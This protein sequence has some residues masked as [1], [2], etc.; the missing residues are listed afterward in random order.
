MMDFKNKYL[1]KRDQILEPYF[2]TGYNGGIRKFKY[3]P[4]E[5]IKQL[6]A[7]GFADSL[8][9]QNE[10]PT[11]KQF[12]KFGEKHSRFVFNG[13]AVSP[14]RSDCRVTVDSIIYKETDS[15]TKEE[16][17]MLEEVAS[18]WEKFTG[19]EMKMATHGEAPWI[20]T[21]PNKVIDYNLAYYRNK[22]GEMANI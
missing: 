3:V 14:N 10:S 8:D 13:Y 4:V 2:T 1:E 22:Y 12:V 16:L 18:K 15:I 19:S 6:I 21:E 17:I 11:L 20:S 5:V 9:Q 7:G